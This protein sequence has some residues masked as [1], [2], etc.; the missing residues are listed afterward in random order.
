MNLKEI[1]QEML[2]KAEKDL[3]QNQV[4]LNFEIWQIDREENEEKKIGKQEEAN[5]LTAQVEM[6]EKSI[7]LFS[8]YIATL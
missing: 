8:E 2:N 3:L 7:S 1:A 6:I 5:K 4:A